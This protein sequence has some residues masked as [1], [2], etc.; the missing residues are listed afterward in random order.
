MSPASRS[1]SGQRG[2]ALIVALLV[3]ALS[4]AVLVSLEKDS[5]L[6]YQRM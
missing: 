4:A 5:Q 1:W 2:A 6:F 3:F